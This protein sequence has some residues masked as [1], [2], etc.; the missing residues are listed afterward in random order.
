MTPAAA[1]SRR[2]LYRLLA[3]EI[4]GP[5]L[6]FYGLRA[7]GVS[8]WL[9]LLAGAVL[10]AGR[11][12]HGIVKERRVS[13]V[14]LFVLGT[15]SL[16]VAMSSVTGEA[17]V[18]LIRDAWGS[19]AMALWLLLSVL[20]AKPALYEARM[21]MAGD[22]RAAWESS[23]ERRPAFRRALWVFTAVWGVA[24]ALD[25][26]VRVLMA[27]TLP[28]DLV[29]VLDDVL[30]AVTLLALV[31]IQRSWGPRYLRRHGLAMRGAEVYRLDAEE[32]A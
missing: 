1:T 22:R 13:G 18:L 24:F 26:A 14:T 3:I 30:L 11:A 8:Q 25:I 32:R 21:F 19:A 20:W 31:A 17:R 10:P 23:W 7:A 28:I 6:I 16:T 4:A 9:A 5:L 15:M 12:V 27:M 2:A 29:P